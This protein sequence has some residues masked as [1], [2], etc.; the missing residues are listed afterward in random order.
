MPLSD[1]DAILAA[2]RAE[3]ADIQAVAQRSADALLR[4]ANATSCEIWLWRSLADDDRSLERLAVAGDSQA[5][6]NQA[7]VDQGAISEPPFV[8]AVRHERRADGD[9][10]VH[11]ALGLYG[12]VTLVRKGATIDDATVAELRNA[13]LPLGDR[14]AD[15]LP[16][17]EIALT[18]RWLLVRGELDRRAA[19][20]FASVTTVEE[21]GVLIE[22]LA[23]EL[24]PIEY[25]GIYFVDPATATLKLVYAKGLTDEERRAAERTAAQRHPGQV[26]RTGRA[27]D[28]LDTRS[29]QDPNAPDGHG[30]EV[31]SRMYL[32]VRIGGLVVGTI[33]FASSRPSNFGT[34]HRQ[35]LA[36]LTDLAGVTYAR[37]QAQAESERNS[38]LIEATATANERLLAAFDWRQAAT[39][40][41]GLVGGMLRAGALALVRLEQEHDSEQLDFVW[42]PMFGVPWPNRERIARLSRDEAARLARGDAIT[43]DLG[44]T[45]P[46][47]MLKPSILKPSIL[48]PSILKPLIIE[49]ALW[50]VLCF[51]YRERDDAQLSRAERAA[52]RGLAGG[53]VNAIA[54]ERVDLA[55]RER[56]KLDAVSKLA[57]GIAHDFN[58]LLWPILL[59]SEMLERTPGLDAR[60]LQMLRD[61]RQAA[62]RASELVQQVLT[63]SRSRGRELQLVNISELAIEV[64]STVRRSA[65]PTV[66]VIARIDADAGHVLGEEQS[67]RQ[68]FIGLAA[69]ALEALGVG[70]SEADAPPVPPVP[71]S[72]PLQPGVL[73][74]IVERVERDRAAWMR[75]A[76]VDSVSRPALQTAR[77]DLAIESVRRIAVQFNGRMHVGPAGATG[78]EREVLLPIAGNPASTRSAVTLQAT[79]TDP[80]PTPTPV[81]KGT[82]PEPAPQRIL[83]VDD[84]PAVLEVARQ[85][86]ASLG[87][88]VT[89]CNEPKRAAAMLAE[90]SRPFDLLLT[91]L[92]M[93]GMDGL[94]LARESKRLR[95]HMPVVCCT[96]FGDARS[97]RIA[98][99]I[100]VAAFIR[101]PIDFDHYERT[102]RA[103]IGG[104]PRGSS[105]GGAG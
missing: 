94:E 39:A 57:G 67:V 105:G 68:I 48:K 62:T 32:P 5:V 91:D 29:E 40:A 58:N 90:P 80:A 14:L 89:A 24:F 54:R 4:A 38:K 13:M 99:E 71:P 86:L 8:G 10:V 30:R 33:G 88:D 51:E 79:A 31:R 92:S 66:E 37:L 72:P 27:V 65:P 53:F 42:Q 85:I 22:M 16:R 60:A 52:L 46:G 49:G 74:I 78:V 3:G 6:A 100:G 50:G 59:Y 20:S 102:I 19:T 43:V 56:Q 1:L 47:A 69:H 61:M 11:L 93:P 101:K 75:V 63:I 17:Q 7:L 81:S 41:L 83:L 34:R 25:S 70:S 103:A 2:S 64:S 84:D 28:I 96:G 21:L 73:E 77:I 15:L 26:L 44:A 104:S 18:N 76:F 87:Y 36:F 9:H 55:L 82:A 45:A 97:E 95:P 23:D 98:S 35:V 12:F